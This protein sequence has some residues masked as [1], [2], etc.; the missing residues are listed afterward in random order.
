[1]MP[2]TDDA[3]SWKRSSYHTPF[4]NRGGSKGS[5]VYKLKFSNRGDSKGSKVY[6]LKFSSLLN[7]ERNVIF[8]S[9]MCNYL[10]Y[11]RPDNYISSDETEPEQ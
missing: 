3:L 9:G 5:K 11:T 6:K 1:M 2:N 7:W 10:H 4:N 8:L